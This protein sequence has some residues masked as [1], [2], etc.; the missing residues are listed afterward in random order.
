MTSAIAA[1]PK[2]A[3]WLSQRQ[4][5]AWTGFAIRTISKWSSCGRFPKPVPIGPHHNSPR[6]WVRAEVEQWMRER[7]AGRE[8]P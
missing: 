5:A 6:R 4:V 8:Q 3:R 1:V 7:E 2:D